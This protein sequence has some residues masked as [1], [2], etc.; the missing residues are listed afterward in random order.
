MEE[1]A[2]KIHSKISSPSSSSDSDDD[3]RS[4]GRAA[5]LKAKVYRLFG[6]EKP[7]HQVLGAG[8]RA[9]FYLNLNSFLLIYCFYI[10]I[11]SAHSFI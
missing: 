10:D 7:I 9:R 8:K 6:R 1:L 11:D 3:K 2:H 5:A 4:Q